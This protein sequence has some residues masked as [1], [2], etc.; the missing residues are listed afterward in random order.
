MGLALGDWLEIRQTPMSARSRINLLLIAAIAVAGP[1]LLVSARQQ[2][3][4]KPTFTATVARVPISAVV[5]DSKK[6][7]VQT[8]T[9]EEFEVLENGAPRTI[10]DFSINE[11]API[12]IA[13]LF[14]TS[15][16]MAVGSSLTDAKSIVHHVLEWIEPNTDE[17]ALFTFSR[18]LHQDVPFTADAKVID[19]ALATW[20]R[21]DRRRSTMPLARSP[22]C[23]SGVPR[24]A[25]ALWS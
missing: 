9:R 5:T 20:S 14:D 13:L 8:L 11:R 2:D 21:W 22:R 24:C 1:T 17:I 18:R 4:A 6:R 10:V 15:G 19:R 16:S 7:R 3:A 12:S 23:S 25:R